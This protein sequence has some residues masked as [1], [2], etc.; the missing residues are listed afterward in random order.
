MARSLAADIGARA[1]EGILNREI[2]PL[3]STFVLEHVLGQGVP[4]RLFL[5]SGPDDRF[6]VEAEPAGRTRASAGASAHA[7]AAVDS[8]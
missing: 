8:S 3:I 6:C 1:I 7:E 5:T 2:L 4:R